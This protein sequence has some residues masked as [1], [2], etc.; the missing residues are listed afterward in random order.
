[1]LKTPNR[2]ASTF[3]QGI[4][5]PLGSR[6]VDP[7]RSRAPA[8]DLSEVVSSTPKLELTGM[9]VLV[10]DDS[11]DTTEMLRQL[12]EINGAKVRTS[13]SGAEALEAVS[14]SQF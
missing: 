8:K 2:S 4:T 1:M 9:G 14:Q 13:S 12:L 11:A 3:V 5:S 10:I 6:L 7:S